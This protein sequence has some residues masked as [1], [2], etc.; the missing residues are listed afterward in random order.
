MGL[1]AVAVDLACAA[2]GRLLGMDWLGTVPVF[3]AATVA[4]YVRGELLKRYVNPFLSAAL[5]SFLEVYAVVVES[6]VE[7]NCSC[8]FQSSLNK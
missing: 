2:F 1:V 7:A 8:R 5:V 4:Q 6:G 3:L